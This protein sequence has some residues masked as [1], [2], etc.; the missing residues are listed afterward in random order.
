MSKIKQ[1]VK[2]HKKVMIGTIIGGIGTAALGIVA[3][4]LGLYHGELRG[5]SKLMAM[6][7]AD[8]DGTTMIVD[9]CLSELTEEQ[10]RSY[11]AYGNDLIRRCND[12]GVGL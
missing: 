9:H 2:D 1:F 3:Y 11:I 7:N 10:M 12:N 5:Y 6:I 8:R 4:D